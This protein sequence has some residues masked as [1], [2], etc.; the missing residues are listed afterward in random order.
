MNSIW[1]ARIRKVAGFAQKGVCGLTLRQSD[2][3]FGS[4]GE[5]PDLT[6][7]SHAMPSR[8]TCALPLA[9]TLSLISAYHGRQ[10]DGTPFTNVPLEQIKEGM[11]EIKEA[12]P[13][14]NYDDYGKR[15]LYCGYTGE[16]I[17]NK[18]YMVPVFYSKLKHMVADKAHCE[19]LDHEVLTADGWKFFDQ[20]TMDSKIATLKDGYLV[21]EKPIKLLYFPD[22][23]GK[24][25]HIKSQQIDLQVTPEHRMW[26]ELNKEWQLTKI[27]DML[28]ETVRYQ[29]DALWNGE[30]YEGKYVKVNPDDEHLPNYTWNLSRG[31]CRNMMLKLAPNGLIFRCKLK[32]MADDFMRLC[33]HAG[34]SANIFEDEG[35]GE[36]KVCI[37]ITEWLNKPFLGPKN[38]EEIDFEGPV[39]CLQVPSEV[40]YTRRNGKGCW[41]GNSRGFGS[42]QLLT[43]Q[44]QEGR[45]KDG[46]LRF[47]EMERD[48][49]IAHG[50]SAF[51]KERMVDCS[52]QYEVFICSRCQ[53]YAVANPKIHLYYCP[54]CGE[55]KHVVRAETVYAFKLMTQEVGQINT[56]PRFIMGKED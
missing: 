8:M 19:S 36:Y 37:M 21:Y 15:D 52:D 11:Q 12:F 13:W 35:N 34:C 27:K 48:A 14:A 31:K 4:Y 56:V 7:N 49:I 10:A 28:E 25:Y 39:F 43:R 18:I 5:T 50:T 38:I 2:L 16:K 33:L 6:I 30:I 9:G 26:V 51:L 22:Y 3:A 1:G 29:K 47:G 20:L 44:P 45:A 17:A 46:G 42:M 32:S 55:S 54:S 23:K 40:F 24:M 53:D 41:T